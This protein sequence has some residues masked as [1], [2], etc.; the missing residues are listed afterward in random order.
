M[1]LGWPS[2]PNLNMRRRKRYSVIGLR[3]NYD[4]WRAGRDGER[5]VKRRGEV[6]MIR[7]RTCDGRGRDSL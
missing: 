6:K 4:Q 3:T 2:R 7:G 1:G 5:H